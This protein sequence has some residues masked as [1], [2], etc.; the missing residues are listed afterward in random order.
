M[1]NI[2]LSDDDSIER[3]RDLLG[4]RILGEGRIVV[5][6]SGNVW[7][8]GERRQPRETPMQG[9]GAGFYFPIRVKLDSTTATATG[10]RTTQ[11]AFRYFAFPYDEQTYEDAHRL[12]PA[13]RLD[14]RPRTT[15]G[16]YIP[17][18]DGSVGMGWMDAG[19]IR[20]IAW[21]EVAF[22]EFCG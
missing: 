15:T 3:L 18:P 6:R 17:A 19:Q 14:F 9:G 7:T 22:S 20:L 21:K 16:R 13:S 8:V 5:S 12:D 10:T 11:C 2:V 4:M 1:I